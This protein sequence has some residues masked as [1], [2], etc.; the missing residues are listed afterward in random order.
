MTDKPRPLIE[1]LP[2]GC[3]R[4]PLQVAIASLRRRHARAA[5]ICYLL[6]LLFR[7]VPAQ[8]C[9]KGRNHR[10][11]KCYVEAQGVTCHGGR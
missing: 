4:D 11:E 5:V 1:P 7:G 3:Y 6:V 2:S 10:S 8:S 9:G